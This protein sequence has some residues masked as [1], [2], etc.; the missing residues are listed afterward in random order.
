MNKKVLIFSIV[1]VLS[2][3]VMASMP[4]LSSD[5]E[6]NSAPFTFWYWMYGAVSKSGIHADLVGMKNIGLRGCYL[7]PIRG[8]SDKPEFKGNANQLSPQFWNDVDYTFQQAD[9]LGL[10]LGIHISDGFA[11]AGGPWVTPA[12][13]MQ[14]VVWTDTIVNSK[15]LKGLVLRR[16]EAYDGYYEDI[17]CWAIPLE[18]RRSCSKGVHYQQPFFLKWNIADSKTLQ[19]TSAMTRDKN[20]IFRSSEPCSILYDLGNIQIVRSLQV[21]PSGNN[22][23]SQR[24]T[25]LASNDGVD[26]RKVIQLTPARQGWQSYGPSFTYSFP[27]TAARYFRFEWTPAGTEPGSEDLDP[28]KWKP[29]LK[30]KDIILSNE[31]KINQ[32]EGKTGA[33][34]RIAS[35]T[36]SEDVPDQNC[37]RLEDMIRLQLQGDKVISVINSV[38]KHSSLKNGEKIRILRFGHTSIGQM[39]TTAGGGKGLEVDKFNRE[40]VDKQ[41]NNWYQKFLDRPHSLVVKYLHVDSWECGTQ[42]WGAD[43]LQ[44]FQTRRGYGLLPYLPLYA[45]IPMV[46]AERS[47]KVLKDIRLTVNDLVNEVFFRRVKYWGIQ[48]GKKVSHESIAPTFVA[49]GLEHYHYADLPMGEFWLNSPTHDKPNDMLDAVSG[50]HIYGKNVVQAEG[51]TEVRGVW[52][53]TPAMLKPLLDREFA[54]GMNRLF[55][56][57]DAH[58]PWMDR[59]PGMTLD[60]IGLFFQ[61]DNTWYKESKGFVDYV[62]TCQHYLQQGHPVVDIAAFT[63]EEMPSRSLTPD[64][65]VSILPGIFGKERVLSEQKRLENVGQPMEE[66]PVGVSHSAGILD[67]KNWVNALHGYKYDSINKD[68]LLHQAT[69]ADGR[70]IMPG[71]VSYRVL[72]LP[73]KT[74]MDPDFQGYSSEVQAKIDECRKAG[75]LVIDH[76]YTDTDFSKYNLD[77]DVILPPDIAW[78]HRST[79][80]ME[81]YFIANQKDSARYITAQFRDKNRIRLYLEPYESKFVIIS[82]NSQLRVVNLQEKALGESIKCDFLPWKMNFYNLSKVLKSDTLFDWTTSFNPKICYYS[83]S[84]CYSTVFKYDKKEACVHLNLG[85]VHD[86]AHVYVNRVDCGIAWMAP[87]EVDITKAIHRGKN[88]LDI[89]VTNTWRNALLGAEQG[90]APFEGIWTNSEYRMKGNKLLPAGLIGPVSLKE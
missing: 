12:E 81:I 75:V 33:S 43:F 79:G 61:R 24:L 85:Q 71:G 30:L 48:Y 68:A 22:I 5:E 74:K 73:G 21:I 46:S 87:Y 70:I 53:E 84:V 60:G 23:Q 29:V 3:S 16:P 45:G 20:G 19:Y 37:I 44:A 13:S 14:K 65:L 89:V 50:A 76:P 49:D 17:A 26:F 28:A 41:V 32:W 63:G 51:F 18:N 77:P 78:T 7:M 62:T 1:F 6:R 52:N 25:V 15:D 8:I 86:I 11:L 47:E 56:H 58:N 4:L 36:S 59:K 83:G 72:V 69:I 31:P 38:S 34:W 40:A 2:S 54:L 57:V 55:F 90:K 66:S 64:R 80:N 67:M 88:I 9:S 27:A 42:N 39:N 10:E 82:N 35:T